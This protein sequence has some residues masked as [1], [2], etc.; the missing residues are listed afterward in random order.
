MKLSLNA[1]FLCIAL[2]CFS[3]TF[4][5]VEA[6]LLAGTTLYGGDMSKTPFIIEEAK[7]AAQVFGEYKFS[8]H[9][10]VNASLLFG[11][12]SGDDLNKETTYRRNLRFESNIFEFGAK[13]QYDILDPYTS[14]IVPYAYAG[15]AIFHHNPQA[16]V[17]SVMVELQPLGTEGQGREGYDEKYKL[18]DFSIPV[19]VGVKYALTDEINL[20]A[21]IGARKTFTNYLDDVGSALYAVPNDLLGENGNETTA[22]KAAYKA[23]LIESNYPAYSALN[24]PQVRQSTPRTV[25]S[26]NSDWYYMFGIGASY[27][28]GSGTKSRIPKNRKGVPYEY[29]RY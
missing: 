17:D 27:V 22:Y 19:G 25:D 18:W 8:D 9:L 12:I 4:A 20:R 10:G 14:R 7:P 3:T 11:K 2:F 24:D 26:S 16:E 6:G 15:A 5:Q 29:S 21:D 1:T 13:V 28:F 23:D